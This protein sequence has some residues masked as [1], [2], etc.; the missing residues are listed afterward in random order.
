VA[1]KIVSLNGA[2]RMREADES[3]WHSATVPGCV[4]TDL[5]TA[6]RIPDPF[7][8]LNEGEVG[9]VSERD[10]EYERTF[11]ADA[12][13]LS[14]DRVE[15]VCHGLDTFARLELNGEELGR[16]ENAF[17]EHAFDMQGRLTQGENRLRI[18]F[19]SARRVCDEREA[20]HGKLPGGA[21]VYA[22]KPQY[23]F[24]WDWGPSLPTCGIWRDIELR[25]FR[26]GC[27]R[28]LQTS[29]VPS[30]DRGKVRM[31]LALER[32]DDVPLSVNATLSRGERIVARAELHEVAD[33]AEAAL[34]VARPDL[35]WPSGCGDAALYDLCVRVRKGG[36]ELDRRELRIG[37]RTI[38][39]ERTEDDEGE[40]FI[41]KVN[42]RRIFCRGTNWIPA[43]SFPSRLT[44]PTCRRLL[45]MAVDQNMN[46][47][48]VWGGGMYEADMFYELCDELGLLV[49][50]DFMF[51]CGDYPDLDS[52][53][54]E[55]AREAEK[56]VIRL[57]HHPS[58][59]LWCGNNE[60]HMGHDNWGW[61]ETFTSER[62]YHEVLPGVCERLDPERP[63]WP[64]CPYGGENSNCETH[65]DMHNWRIWHRG[66]DY[67]GY[68]ECRGRFISEFGFQSFP[69]LDTVL[70]FAQPEDLA[71]DSEVMS[72]HQKCRNGNDRLLEAIELFFPAPENFDQTM[73]FT[74]IIHGEALR[75]GIEHWRRLK[76]HTSGTLFWQL[77][78]CWPAISWA[79]VDA[80]LRP[81]PAYYHV[82][83]AYAPVLV[84]AH[85]ADGQVIV[86]G[87][88]D[89]RQ[90]VSGTMDI[91]LFDLRGEAHVLQSG[92]VQVPPDAAV[93]LCRIPLD[94]IEGLDPRRH[95]LWS[96]LYSGIHEQGCILLFAEP[97]DLDFLDPEMS[98]ETET[99]AFD[100]Q[101]QLRIT[102]TTFTKGVWLSVPGSDV[103]FSDN[104]F[105]LVPYVPHEVTVRFGEGPPVD[106]LKSALRIQ[107]CNRPRRPGS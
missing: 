103:R 26:H 87:I 38:E 30:G 32:T 21:R 61:P 52:F 95:F 91:E 85:V 13:L 64:G 42:G 16:T 80:G 4:H 107:H 89:T 102:A 84:T 100:G 62:I 105:D 93:E 76:W 19:D 25:A 9:W 101:T 53:R 48:R 24:G 67:R 106:D 82:R 47:A 104:A 68:R 2:W 12:E 41:F 15:L 97:K 79:T 83:R 69:T 3:D 88:N 51:A 99:D 35:W 11:E 50:Q 57:R 45:E 20:E 14:Q 78:D 1:L 92:T 5:M 58:L 22:R 72:A 60:N 44:P 37:F 71:M 70:E 90:G 17:V 98:V 66:R 8:R 65:G 28:E 86:F 7:Y 75:F 36:E 73:L 43:D 46:M 55:V 96:K 54:A 39:L 63:Y 33:S 59:A 6:G 27:I 31:E 81:K 49:W 94:E 74:Q 77:N 23:S 40:S 56:V 34:D 18:R 10:W 29:A